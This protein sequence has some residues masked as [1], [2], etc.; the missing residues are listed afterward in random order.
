M[1]IA[2]GLN[3]YHLVYGACWQSCTEF[4]SPMVTFNAQRGGKE[5]NTADSDS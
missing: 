3:T 4:K 5:N 1:K 2:Y